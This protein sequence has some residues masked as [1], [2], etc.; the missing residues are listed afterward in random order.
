MTLCHGY[1]YYALPDAFSR[2][3]HYFFSFLRNGEQREIL[4]VFRR[5]LRNT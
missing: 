5:T 3:N 1:I 4:L 2:H